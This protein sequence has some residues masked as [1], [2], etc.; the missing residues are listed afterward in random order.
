MLKSIN[1]MFACIAVLV[2]RGVHGVYEHMHY[3]FELCDAP[4]FLFN[5]IFM[6]INNLPIT[7]MVV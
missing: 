2:K 5:D 4:F 6:C 3:G 1:K 7:T